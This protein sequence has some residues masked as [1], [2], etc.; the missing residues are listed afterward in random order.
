MDVCDWGAGGG[1]GGKGG[2]EHIISPLSVRTSVP[3]RNTNGFR[4]ISFEKVSVLD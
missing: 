2:A 3:L 1:G 4:L